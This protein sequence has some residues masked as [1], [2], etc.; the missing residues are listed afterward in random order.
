MM[1]VP[2]IHGKWKKAQMTLSQQL[3]HLELNLNGKRFAKL[4]SKERWREMGSEADTCLRG[5]STDR[6]R[7]K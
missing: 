1:K 3:G 6:V 4:G 2:R 5:H 7:V